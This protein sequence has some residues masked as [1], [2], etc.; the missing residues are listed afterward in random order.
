MVPINASAGHLMPID[1]AP[2]VSGNLKSKTTYQ[3]IIL[4]CTQLFG[5]VSPLCCKCCG[6]ERISFLSLQLCN[7]IIEKAQIASSKKQ[8]VRNFKIYLRCVSLCVRRIATR[9]GTEEHNLRQKMKDNFVLRKQIE[10]NA[11]KDKVWDVLTNPKFSKILG[12]ELDKNAFLK[13]EWKLGSEVYFM[14]EPDKIVATGKITEFILN[15]KVYTD[16]AD[17]NYFDSFSLSNSTGNTI[18]EIRS[19]PYPQDYDDQLIVWQKWLERVQK[20]CEQQIV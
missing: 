11:T 4:L 19:G 13:S 14:Y 18:L 20:L 6:Y 17:I 15:T 1:F 9:P 12:N 8:K 2:I 7:T 16:Y 10:I 5:K 3:P